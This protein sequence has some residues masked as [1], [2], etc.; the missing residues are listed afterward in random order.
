[1]NFYNWSIKKKVQKMK[2]NY[3]C[4]TLKAPYEIKIMR[5][6]LSLGHPR[7]SKGEDHG[8]LT[9]LRG[10]NVPKSVPFKYE[11]NKQL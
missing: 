10:I 6:F 8:Y 1:M 3:H 11:N 9:T 2:V 7:D 5:F 4:N